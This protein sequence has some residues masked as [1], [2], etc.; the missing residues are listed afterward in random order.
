MDNLVG[1]FAAITLFN[2]GNGAKA[3]DVF[4]KFQARFDM[5][6]EE[7]KNADPDINEQATALTSLLRSR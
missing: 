2:A 7:M 4:N 3:Q 5:W 1:R 6:D